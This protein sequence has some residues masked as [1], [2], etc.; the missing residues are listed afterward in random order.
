M[1]SYLDLIP[2]S[3]RIH[4]KQSRMTR[5]CILLAVF[6]VTVIFGM[7]DMEIRAQR[8]QALQKDGGWHVGFMGLSEEQRALLPLR[9]EIESLARYY[10][11][12]YS[13]DQDYLLEGKQAVICGFDESFLDMFPSAGIVE[14]SFPADR[15][16]I[17]VTRWAREQLGLSLGDQVRLTRPDK[18]SMIFT[19]TGFTGDTSMLTV[20]DAF[21]VYMNMEAMAEFG[22]AGE[23]SS[24]DYMNYVQFRSGTNIRQVLGDMQSRLGIQEEQIAQN[25]MLLALMGQSD[26][27]YIGNLYATAGILAVLVILAGVLMIT[28]S[29]NSNVAQRTEFFGM[30]RC[31]GAT[32]QQVVRFVRLEALH[33]CLTAIPAGLLCATLVIWLL[34]AMLRF[35]SPGYFSGM[36]VLGVSFIGLALGIVVG[37]FTVLLAAQTPA[38]RAAKVSPLTAVSGNAGSQVT[39]K[40]AANTRLFKI[41]TALGIHH[42]KESRKNFIL[43]ICSFAFSII[44]FLS[45]SAAVDF[46]NHAIRPTKPYTPDYVISSPDQTG[47]LPLA[48][49]DGLAQIAGVKRVFGRMYAPDTPVQVDGTEIRVNLISYEEHQ[50]GWSEEYLLEGGMEEVKRGEGVLVVYD[51]D[52]PVTKGCV[53]AFPQA[54]DS[55]TVTG[56]VSTSPFISDTGMVTVISSEDVFRRLTG[57]E[58]YA[59]MEL[60]L[61]KDCTDE[62]VKQIRALAGED[63]VFSDR[64]MKNSE[65][66]GAYYSMALF[67]YGFLAVIAMISIF[68][69]I[70]SIAMSVSAR[71]GQYGAMRAIGMDEGQLIRM[72]GAEAV[73]YG[74]CGVLLGCAAGLPL[75][76]LMYEFLVTTRWGDPW[77]VPVASLA[78]I[79]VIVGGALVL[80]VWG[81]AKRIRRMSIVDTVSAL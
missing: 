5:I 81:P 41:Y 11:L 68:N 21:G 54:G 20:S 29:M 3:A 63:K 33:W 31:L 9:P 18:T 40:R 77:Y 61:N 80:A 39:I 30:I 28:G 52:S 23:E 8:M 46:M 48:L 45:F 12:N 25:V 76:K 38:R 7:A 64:R 44:L 24:K 37:L 74:V 51:S 62:D 34:C 17:V 10:V 67:I 49:G 6:L 1:K 79:L 50:F 69:I 65:A 27:S 57:Q 42:A 14:G 22:P 71:I 70:N 4:K 56:V 60:Q 16:S 55:L 35:L 66:R 13:L 72:V 73:A 59:V 75:N 43:M 53:L 78:T 19:V 36:P 15:N 32:G 26:N 2:V 47:S 58:G